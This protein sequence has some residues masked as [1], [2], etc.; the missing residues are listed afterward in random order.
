MNK[1]RLEAFSDGILAIIITIMVLDLK[2]P[3]NPPWQSYVDAYPIFVSYALSFILVGLYWSTHHHLFHNVQKVNNKVLW[4]NMFALFWQSL[5]PFAT[6]SMGENKFTNVTVIVYALVLTFCTISHTFLV[7]SLIRLH[8]K[9]S[10][11]STIANKD[12]RKGNITLTMN[13]LAIFIAYLGY[14]RVAFLTIVLTAIQW[15]IPNNFL[16]MNLSSENNQNQ[17][18]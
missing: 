2:V 7:N 14:P 8:G 15:F 9:N 13:I 4:M 12:K 10:N 17:S 1:N 18:S 6:A 5:I 11:F 16:G 3:I